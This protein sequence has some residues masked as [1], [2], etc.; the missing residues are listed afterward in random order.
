LLLVLQLLDL[1]AIRLGAVVEPLDLGVSSS[2]CVEVAVWSAR[3]LGV[4]P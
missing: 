1:A 2:C 3:A 4:D